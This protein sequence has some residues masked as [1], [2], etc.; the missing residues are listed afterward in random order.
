MTFG[1]S[2]EIAHEG[3]KLVSLLGEKMRSLKL[4]ALASLISTSFISLTTVAASHAG[5]H[6]GPS[7][8]C[9][10]VP[11][12]NLWIS[13]DQK[14]NDGITK[15]EFFEINDTMEKL[16]APIVKKF[17]GNLKVNKLWDDGTVNASA[18]QQGSTWIVNMYGGLARFSGMTYDGFALVMCHELGH[19]LGGFPKNPG[20]IT[21]SWASNEGQSD[22]FATMKCFREVYGRENN[23]QRMEGVDVPAVVEESCSVQHKTSSAIALCKRAAM[24]GAVLARVLGKLGQ[25]AEPQFE[26]PDSTQ[27]S[28]TNNRHP[29]A[30]CRMDTYF[31]GAV[32]GI[33]HKV[34]FGK[35]DAITG[36]CAEERGDK[37]GVRSRCWYKPKL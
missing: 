16:Y 15:E 30:Q 25:S 6:H 28:A 14:T 37:F 5:H 26:T 9:N 24:G 36:A 31:A 35:E 33:S 12:N 2:E 8:M 18:Q 34:D 17:G 23:L 22:Y 13:A 11:E 29:K 10:F 27:V 1:K 19:H 21:P 20:L 7:E 3:R 4:I 32:C